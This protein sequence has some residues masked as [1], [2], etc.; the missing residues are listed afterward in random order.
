MV[1]WVRRLVALVE[2]LRSVSS[3]HM[4]VYNHLKVQLIKYLLS[5]HGVP[6]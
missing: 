3:I 6:N 1:Q 5:Q 4:A 2:D